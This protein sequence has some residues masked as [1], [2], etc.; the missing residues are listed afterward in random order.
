ML[1]ALG[2][3]TLAGRTEVGVIVLSESSKEIM[4]GMNFSRRFE[5]AL[6]VSK[7]LGVSLIDEKSLSKDES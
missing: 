4:V 1:T 7:K 5:R 2:T 3:A 6:V